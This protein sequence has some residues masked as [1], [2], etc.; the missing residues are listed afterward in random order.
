MD[1]HYLHSSFREQLIEHLF[2]GELLKLSWTQGGC[3]LEVAKSEVDNQGYDLIVEDKG[4]IRH[5]QLKASHLSAVAAGQ[6]IHI[7]LSKKPSGCVVWIYFN[8]QTLELGPFLLLGAGPGEPLPDISEFRVAK[9]AK[10]NAEG[11]KAERPD[12]RVVNKGQFKR[13]ETISELYSALFG[14]E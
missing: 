10:A 6:K 14:R 3:S 7:G 1:Q 12:I 4:V 2:V 8:E 11:V 9:H 5:I 13:Y